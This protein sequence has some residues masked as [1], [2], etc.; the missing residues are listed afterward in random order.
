MVTKFANTHGVGQRGQGPRRQLHD[1]L[2]PAALPSAANNRYPANT[3][4]GEARQRRRPEAVRPR[5]RRRADAEH[6]CDGQ[7]LD[8]PRQRLGEGHEGRRRHQG[9]RRLH[10]RSTQHQGERSGAN[11]PA[12]GATHAPR[13]PAPWRPTHPPV[14]TEAVRADPRSSAP[15]P[16][17]APGR[18]RRRADRPLLSGPVGL[19]AEARSCSASS[20]RSP[21]GPPRPRE[22]GKWIALGVL[23]AATIAIDVVYLCRGG[24]RPAQVPG[25]R[26]DLPDRVPGRPDHLQRQRRVHELVDGHILTK[27]EAI[28][29]VQRNSLAPRPGRQDLRDG[30]RSRRGG[31]ARAA[32]ARRGDARAPSSAPAR[33]WSRSP[34][35]R[36]AGRTDGLITG[37][38]RATR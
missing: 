1:A 28:E 17:R 16:E 33:A 3:D 32:P 18:C 14:S 27:D 4:A 11:H 24:T 12:G 37:A 9:P 36:R 13:A 34:E 6:P 20:T 8:R 5:Q 19:G 23:V 38:P 25:P 31:R 10:G 15:A 29:G 26:D 22:R 7:R 30:A 21:S 35:E 2:R